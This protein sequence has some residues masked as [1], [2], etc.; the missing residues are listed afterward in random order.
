MPAGFKIIGGDG[1]LGES[2]QASEA[3]SQRSYGSGVAQ[4]S[5]R[6]RTAAKAVEYAHFAVYSM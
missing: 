4:A 1:H 2:Y 3:G 5:K 6:A